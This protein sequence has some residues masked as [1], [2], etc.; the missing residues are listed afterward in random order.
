MLPA[1]TRY[2]VLPPYQRSTVSFLAYSYT[3]SLTWTYSGP[4]SG[5]DQHM[6]Q[7][8]I[9]EMIPRMHSTLQEDSSS[10]RSLQGNEA[11]R[12]IEATAGIAVPSGQYPT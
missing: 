9:L 12:R 7:V 2:E 3:L 6:E 4:R 8:G 10:L 5:V 1:Y 11:I